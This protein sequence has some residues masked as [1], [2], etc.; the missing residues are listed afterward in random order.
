MNTTDNY[1]LKKPGYEDVA[2][3]S[4][5]NDNM[6]V[7]DGALKQIEDNADDHYL[8]QLNSSVPVSAWTSSSYTDWPYK[9]DITFTN[10]TA[11]YICDVMF[12]PEQIS[13]GIYAPFAEASAGKVTIFA[14]EIPSSAI[15]I[16]A[17]ELRK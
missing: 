16:P 6:D 12:S 10:C 15:I 11:G 2:D 7:I 8:K 3:I 5:I 1:G 4:I 9:A 13:D 14:E 17:I